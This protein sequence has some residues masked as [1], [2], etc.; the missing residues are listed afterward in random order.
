MD[1]VKLLSYGNKIS[2]LLVENKVDLL[3]EN[4]E[5]P[6]LEEFAKKTQFL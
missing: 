1:E 2:Y 5:D 6:K 4:K 3:E